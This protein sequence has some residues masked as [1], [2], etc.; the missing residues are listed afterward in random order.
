MQISL[1]RRLQMQVDTMMVS[2]DGL[3]R[4]EQ[5]PDRLQRLFALDHV[6]TLN[7]RLIAGLQILAGGRG[8]RPRPGTVPLTDLLRAAGQE[9]ADYQ[10]VQL[11]DVDDMV[12]VS[13][14]VAD[15]LIHLLAELLDNAV[16]FSPPDDPVPVH[17][18]RVGDLLRIQISDTG[19]GMAHDLLAAAADRLAQPRRLDL[20]TTQQMGLPVVGIIAQRHRIGVELRSIPGRGTWVDVTI[21]G[22]LW[23]VR[24]GQERPQTTGQ[25]PIGSGGPE[26]AATAVPPSTGGPAVTAWPSEPTAGRAAHPVIF[27]E[28]WRDRKS[29]FDRSDPTAAAPV[30]QQ[31][32]LA[33]VS[34]R[35]AADTRADDPATWTGSGLPV[36][37][38]GRRAFAPPD[39]GRPARPMQR[40]PED[41]RRQMAAFQHGL[42]L[43]A[44]RRSDRPEDY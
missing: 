34:A 20:R 21:P 31:P 39:Q 8:G 23:I 36:R 12:L 18:R 40:Q 19:T 11:A 3:E 4:D 10:R 27:E 22:P 17:A 9:I 16:R 30:R 35:S 29:W 28:L 44:S 5:D 1:S 43:A 15:E 14:D 6:A 26:P 24:R 7:R 33:G 38:P 25:L 37:E 41:V 2:L 42:G 13:G 32:V